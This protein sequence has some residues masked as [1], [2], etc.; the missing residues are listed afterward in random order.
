[1]TPDSVDYQALFETLPG[2]YLACDPDLVVVAVSAGLETAAGKAKAQLLGKAM[3]EVLPE[4]GPARQ[5]LYASLR[6]V[7]EHHTAYEHTLLTNPVALPTANTSAVAGNWHT[8]AWPVFGAGDKIRY[9]LYSVEAL[10]ASTSVATRPEAA[11]PAGQWISN[12]DGGQEDNSGHQ[13]M[14]SDRQLRQILRQVPAQ[15]ATLLGP[16]HVYGFINAQAQQL[17]GETAKVGLPAAVARP[18]LVA[19]GYIRLVDQVYQ[20]GVPFELIE[21]PTEQPA[22][23]GNSAGETLYFD[24]VLQP[25]TDEQGQTQGVL[26]FGVDVTERVRAK[27]RAAELMEEVRF[28]D[29]QFQQVMEGLPQMAWVARPDGGVTYYNKRWYDYTGSNFEEMQD[30]GWEGFLHPDDLATTVQRWQTALSQGT[31]FETEHRWRDQQ[32][33]YRWFLARGEAVRAA[34]GT[35]SRWVGTNTDIDEQKRFQQQLAAK[36]EQL[37]QILLQSP[38][39]IA[40][41]EGPEHRFAFTNPGYDRLVGYRARLGQPVVECMPELVEQ[42]FIDLLDNVYRTGETFV[43]QEI[44]IELL[45][46]ASGQRQPVY[47]DFTYQAL[48]DA[49]GEIHG[50]LAF[51]VDVT[52]QV[53]ARQRTEA[54][55]QEVQAGSRQLVQQRE[56]FYQLF[57]QTP[58]SIAILRGPEHRFDYFNPRYQ[59]LF[60]DLELLGRPM[61]EALPETVE[62]GFVELLDRVYRTG[63]TFFGDELPFQV[64]SRD[65]SNPKYL[66]FNFTY[67]VFQEDGATVGVAIFAYDVTEQVKARRQT[68]VLQ[69]K[70]SRRDREL[71]MMAES[72]PLITFVTETDGRLS[73]IS[74]QWYAYSGNKLTPNLSAFWVDTVHPDDL[75]ALQNE[76]I[77]AANE[78]RPWRREFRVLRHDGQYR[79]HLGQGVPDLDLSTGRLR[80]WFGSNTDIHE[81]RELQEQLVLKDQ[82][83]QQILSQVPAYIATVTGPEHRYTFINP[84]YN[85]LMGGR[86]QIGKRVADLLPEMVEQGFVA[87]LDEVYNSR[88]P[89]VSRETPVYLLDPET[90][91]RREYYLDFVYQPLQDEHGQ[92]QGILGFSIDVTQQ[93]QARQQTAALQAELRGRD[94]QFRFLAESIPQIMWTADADGQVDYFN[95]Q[96]WDATGRH[97]SESLGT[98][99]WLHIIH[100][101]DQ[102]RTQAAWEEATRTGGKYEIEYRFVSRLGGY[103]WFL[104]RAEPLRDAA[105]EVIKWFGSCTDIDDFKQAQQHLQT[106]NAQLIRINQDLDNFVYTASHDLRQPIYNMAGIFE[107]L[108]RTTHF[109]DPDTAEL[110]AMFEEALQ[111][112]YGTIQDLADLVQVQR[113]H[114]QVPAEPVDVKL[115][116]QSVIRSMQEQVEE[117]GGKFELNTDAV[118]TLLFVR[119][120][121]QSVLYNLLSNALKY[122][123]PGRPPY[124]RVRTDLVDGVPVLTVADNG[125]GIDMA[126]HGAELFQ[127]FRRFHDHVAGSGMGLHLVNRIIQQ[128][129]GR[130]EVESTVGEGTT[131]RVYFSSQHQVGGAAT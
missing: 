56:T 32:G 108:T 87:L 91:G 109:Q 97:P 81:L 9:L 16:D 31:V 113:R 47:L 15:I 35:I 128:A 124:I 58:A 20:T 80:R 105:G 100:P 18:S 107:E 92:T 74:P 123:M 41:A 125:L 7:L 68:Q 26:V 5:S 85:A 126:R 1:M 50:I 4:E 39:L 61:A 90:G 121:L 66:Y 22:S 76:V 71:R 19:T 46:P 27:Q 14:A 13:L 11:G 93:V 86:I 21:M 77:A 96:L 43:G 116:A 114:E 48:R 120:N 25:L 112:I 131:F 6:Y 75:A 110:I 99:A 53:R 57:Q 103:R 60:P 28:Q 24:G 115:L 70:I 117:A 65:G 127:M 102:Q 118:P 111:R 52:M 38:A 94:E 49:G 79:W 62:Q 36:D 44:L 34:N 45:D 10:P 12:A 23:A 84:G 82:Q 89:Y 40:T 106:Q 42:G 55:M 78:L 63:E 101:D 98:V 104:G 2:S 69:A 51:V 30:W 29:Q 83:L 129:G 130:L 8:R 122:A 64:Q 72:L 37:H 54:L 88:K 17:L 119:S 67:Q 33:G 3:A 73:Y 95:Q 59:A